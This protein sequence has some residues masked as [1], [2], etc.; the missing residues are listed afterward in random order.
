MY[1]LQRINISFILSFWHFYLSYHVNP[2]QVIYM[3]ISITRSISLL[4]D[5]CPLWLSSAYKSVTKHKH[6]LLYILFIEIYYLFAC[7]ID[8][9]NNISNT[10]RLSDYWWRKPEIHR[11]VANLQLLYNVSI[12]KA[13]VLLPQE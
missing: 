4:V 7:L 9:F 13:K 10:S 3:F 1:T 2:I 6:G 12:I 8:G 11:P 5:Y